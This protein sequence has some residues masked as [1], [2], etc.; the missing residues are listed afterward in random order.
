MEK[1]IQSLKSQ[2]RGYFPTEEGVMLGECQKPSLTVSFPL[3]DDS[4][5]YMIPGQ[6]SVRRVN[7]GEEGA[8]IEIEIC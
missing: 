2:L 8:I 4:T 6:Q 3:F 5:D 1:V 7:K